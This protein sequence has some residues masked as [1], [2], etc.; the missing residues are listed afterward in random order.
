MRQIRRQSLLSINIIAR[1]E[2]R[3]TNVVRVRECPGNCENNNNTLFY[4][5]VLTK[6][7]FLVYETWLRN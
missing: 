1:D 3:I 5:F 6:C 4:Y 7:L 2:S